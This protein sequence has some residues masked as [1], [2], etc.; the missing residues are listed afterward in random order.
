MPH[1]NQKRIRILKDGVRTKGPVAYWVSR[2]QR[3]SDNWALLYAQ[4]LAIRYN[5]PLFVFFCL[6][7]RFLEATYRQYIFM[8]KGL[9]EL[10]N[11]L[12]RK[13]ISFYLL[14]GEPDKEILKFIKRY[15]IGILVTD[16][17]PLKVK[18]KWKNDLIKKIDIPF[19]EVDAH[20]IVPCWTASNKQEYGAYTI[21][22]K[23]NRLL[24]EY[25][26]SFPR[27]KKQK[28]SWQD[29]PPEIKWKDLI[30]YL[31]IDSRVS[32]VKKIKSGEKAAKSVMKNFLDKKIYTYDR[33]SNDPAK[34]TLSNLSPYLHF[35]Q[36]SAQRVALEVLKSGASQDNKDAF[37]E[38]LIIRR[39]LS[40]NYCFYNNNYDSFE[41]FPNWAKDTLNVHRIDPR[42]Y[43]YKAEELEEAGTHDKLWNAAQLEMTLTGKMHGYMRMYW[44]KKILEWTESP[45]EAQDIA[46]YLNNKY[47]LDGRDPNGYVGIA[48]SIGGLHDRAWKER[49]IFGKVRYMSNKGA[50][51]KFDVYSYINKIK[52][53]KSTLI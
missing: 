47:E 16:F 33:Y 14:S 6:A 9:Q 2:D 12:Y 27:L 19:Y 40:D 15:D 49:P 53:L 28:I 36:I 21:R 11:N 41:G 35:G 23:I 13:N 18:R 5:K 20:N 52:K 44:A 45:E 7:N 38:E 43:I 42:E 8:L 48:W 34:D 17:D 1:I 3:M 31:N 29:K 39:E 22:P 10:E 30:K 26:E 46:V 4:D 25:M 24:P 37:L 50:K 51:S 32:E